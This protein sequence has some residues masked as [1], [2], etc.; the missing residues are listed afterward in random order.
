[1]YKI[2]PIELRDVAACQAI[3][4]ENW[5]VEPARRFAAEVSQVWSLDLD[6]E[7]KPTYFVAEDDDEIVGFAGMIPSWIMHRV[8]DFIWI[9]VRKDRQR[10]GIGRQLTEHRIMKVI[11]ADGRVVQLM[12]E[13]VGF[14]GRWFTV[15]RDYREEGW[16]LMTLQLG[17]VAL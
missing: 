16:M 15:S 17:T 8:W 4:R 2:R 13:D 6:E 9:N 14:F 10:Q 7:F 1:M 5:G 11:A 3:V 12:T